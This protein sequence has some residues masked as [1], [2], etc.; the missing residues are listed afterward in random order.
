MG[1]RF[2]RSLKILPG[3][4]LNFSGSGIS[5]S[6]GGRGAHVTFGHGRVRETIGVPGTGISYTTS[7][8]T[9][10]SSGSTRPNNGLGIGGWIL[11][12]FISM[13]ALSA[14]TEKKVSPGNAAAMS[15]APP[16][17]RQSSSESSSLDTP[18]RASVPELHVSM[19]V[20][21][22]ALNQRDRPDGNVIGVL[23]R[24]A[25]VDVFEQRGEWSRISSASNSQRWVYTSMLRPRNAE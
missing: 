9:R 2:H 24:N 14:L 21:T 8:R 7:R 3:V 13:L 16:P 12:L 4:R 1:F 6:I 18:L 15:V 17:A 25:L 20:A 22:E 5:T 23:H 19:V 11:V 10:N